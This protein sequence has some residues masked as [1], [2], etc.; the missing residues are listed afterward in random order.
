VNVAAFPR[1][2]PIFAARAGIC[3][4]LMR[5]RRLRSRTFCCPLVAQAVDRLAALLRF[6]NPPGKSEV[7]A[8]DYR[9]E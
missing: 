3:F 2:L 8:M 7:Q 6:R 1:P 9:L 4:S 5:M